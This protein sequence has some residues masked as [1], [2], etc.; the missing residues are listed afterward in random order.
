MCDGVM[1]V[2]AR[3]HASAILQI[4]G[5]AMRL[6]DSEVI[7]QFDL[8]G[9]GGTVDMPS[10]GESDAPPPDSPEFNAPCGDTGGT[11]RMIDSF[12]AP[13]EDSDSDSSSEMMPLLTEVDQVPRAW[14][15]ENVKLNESDIH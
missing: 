12:N 2:D 1:M 9:T 6:N 15:G 13:P 11:T 14:S 8:S 7:R 5:R 10:D 4:A 3:S